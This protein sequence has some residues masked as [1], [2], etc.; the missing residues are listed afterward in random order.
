MKEIAKSCQTMAEEELRPTRT[1]LLEGNTLT[2]SADL[3]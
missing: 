1:P 3:T 2:F